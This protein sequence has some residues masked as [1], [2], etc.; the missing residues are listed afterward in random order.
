MITASQFHHALQV[1]AK[2]KKAGFD[3]RAHPEKLTLIRFVNP[4]QR[5]EFIDTTLVETFLMGIEAQRT[6]SG[7]MVKASQDEPI[8]GPGPEPT[9]VVDFQDVPEPSEQAKHLSSLILKTLSDMGKAAKLE[10]SL[11]EKLNS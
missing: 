3:L 5:W 8:T 4:N 11:D 2:C 9:H 1:H 7:E 6:M 10:S